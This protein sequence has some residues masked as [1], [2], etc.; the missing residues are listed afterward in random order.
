MADHDRAS[1][2]TWLPGRATGIRTGRWSTPRS[3]FP[4]ATWWFGSTPGA[5]ADHPGMSTS[6]RPGRP[7][8]SS[9]ASSGPATQS[10]STGLVGLNGISYYAINQWHAASRQPEHL[11]A[12]CVWEGAADCYR[13]MTHHGGIL[14]TFWANWYDMQVKTVQHGLGDRG[15]VSQVTGVPVTGDVTLR[16]TNSRRTGPTSAADIRSHPLDDEFHRDRSP[17]LVDDRRPPPLRG[18]LGWSGSPSPGQRR[19]LRPLR[20]LAQVAGDPRSRALDPLLHRLRGRP[21]RSEFFA[22]YLKGEDNGWDRGHR[23]APDPASRPFRGASSS[24]WPLPETQ[25]TDLF[26]D[27]GELAVRPRPGP[28]HEAEVTYDADRDGDHVPPRPVR[29]GDRGHRAVGR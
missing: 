17:G 5:P 12:M 19:G 15:A 4:T 1:T 6:S 11:A 8:I 2:P 28:R 20:Q 3:G 23:S 25:W 14:S 18:Q 29:D 27:A 7:T 9:P 10:W 21:S 24:P 26:L 13:D 16:T 22:H